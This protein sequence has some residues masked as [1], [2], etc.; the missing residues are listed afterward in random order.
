ML[1]GLDTAVIEMWREE[2]C[3]IRCER[4]NV[5]MRLTRQ[6]SFH[7][8]KVIRLWNGCTTARW[9]SMRRPANLWILSNWRTGCWMLPRWLHG[10]M[11]GEW[12][13]ALWNW[14]LREKRSC[15]Q[16]QNG[17]SARI[18][19]KKPEP[20][21]FQIQYG[22]NGSEKSTISRAFQTLTQEANSDISARVLD[23][24]ENEIALSC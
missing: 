15:W 3:F 17:L 9:L 21:H 1:C 2:M 10:R 12:M 16:K 11:C 6:N 14:F 20:K 23:A 13:M 7:R 5:I 24:N 4:L 19:S 22:A 8:M 18:V